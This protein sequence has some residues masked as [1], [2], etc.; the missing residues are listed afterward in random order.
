MARNVS[1]ARL[2]V[3]LRAEARYA[4]TVGAGM[5]VDQTLRQALSRTQEQLWLDF[6]WKHLEVDRDVV[7]IAG[8]WL[9]DF[10]ADLDQ[11]RVK[12]VETKWGGLW[13]EL[14][15]GIGEGQYNQ[16]DTEAGARTDPQWR[17][18]LRETGQA[19]LWPAPAASGNT[20]R[21]KGIRTLRP[22]VA[23]SDVCDL[24]DNLI[25]LFA[26]AELL[27]AQ[28]A[29]DANIKGTAAA[30]RLA[31]LRGFG[32]RGKSY[33]MTGQPRANNDPRSLDNPA[34]SRFRVTYAR[35]G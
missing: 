16:F 18:R 8:E 25:V 27:T 5:T 1:L 6:D 34:L 31:A 20:I 33:N 12:K 19:E 24:D 7:T 22:L 10:P 35:A 23:D 15:Y 2:L 26:A 21:F 30:R 29:P 13:S 28:K 14:T 32:T 4:Q 3:M 11:E 9:Y 17:W